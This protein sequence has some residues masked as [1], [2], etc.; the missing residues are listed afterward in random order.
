IWRSKIAVAPLLH[1][2]ETF[3]ARFLSRFRALGGLL[4]F[5]L[6]ENQKHCYIS[7]ILPREEG[8]FGRIV[9]NREAGS[10]GRGGAQTMRI[11]RVR[12]SCVVLSPR[13][14]GQVDRD[15]IS[16]L[17]PK[18]RDRSATVA[19]KPEHRGDRRVSRQPIAQGM[20]VVWLLLTTCV[21]ISTLPHTRLSGAACARHSLRPLHFERRALTAKSGRNPR[22][23]DAASC[24]LRGRPH[25]LATSPLAFRHIIHE[26]RLVRAIG[27]P[28]VS[29]RRFGVHN[30]RGFSG[31][32]APGTAGR[33][34]HGSPI[35]GLILSLAISGG[36]AAA[37]P[38]APAASKLQLLT[39][40]FEN[41]VATKLIA[42]AVLLIQQ[43]GRPVYLGTFGVRS[44]R[45]N[46]PMTAD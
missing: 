28:A 35:A 32:G 45:T 11:R 1:A 39:T 30:S 29:R 2:Q 23:G 15:A 21:H 26:T 3:F 25:G 7:E 37:E 42:G 20:P 6:A 34:K 33:V 24:L 18:R 40:F 9:T 43:H 31:R 14:W 19:K 12:P 22:R 17:R 13:R 8:R 46:R 16:A 4:D 5:P 44:V 36:A 27:A 10:G 41:E 38:P